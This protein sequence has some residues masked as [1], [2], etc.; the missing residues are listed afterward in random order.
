MHG[1]RPG[2][3]AA[4]ILASLT[5]MAPAAWADGIS[6]ADAAVLAGGCMACHGPQGVSPGAIPSIAGR[7]EKDLST[8]LLAFRAGETPGATVMTRLMKG[9]D[10]AEIAALARYYA[11]QAAGR[12]P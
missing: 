10:A 4:A 5:A 11:A 2:L 12:A 3:G 8:L 1:L 9:F 7:P 6:P